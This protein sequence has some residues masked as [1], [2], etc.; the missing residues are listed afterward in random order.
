MFPCIHVYFLL[1]EKDVQNLSHPAVDNH[2]SMVKAL[3]NHSVCQFQPIRSLEDLRKKTGH[4][5][6]LETQARTQ[7]IDILKVQGQFFERS[8]P[9]A[10]TN[11]I[12]HLGNEAMQWD[13]LLHYLEV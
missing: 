1:L 9:H 8:D 5:E 7:I 6:I 10:I 2:T 4:E 3:V 12:E 13:V 11:L